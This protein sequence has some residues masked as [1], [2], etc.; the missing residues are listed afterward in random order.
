MEQKIEGG[1]LDRATK[2]QVQDKP[3]SAAQLMSLIVDAKATKDLLQG[4]LKDNAGAFAASVIDLYNSDTTLQQ[5]DPRQVFGECLKAASLKLPINKQLGFAWVIP[6]RDGKTGKQVPQFQI[7]YKGLVQLAMRSGVYRFI[8]AGAVLDGELKNEDKLRGLIDLSGEA[9]QGA[10]VIGYFA[11]IETLN[12]FSKALYW[13]KDKVNAH[14]RK[15]SKS[16]R[17]GSSIWRDNFDEMA[18]KTLLSNLLSH[19][20]L[21]SVE[22]QQAVS[23]DDVVLADNAL[24]QDAPVDVTPAPLGLDSGE[25]DSA[26]N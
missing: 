10:E 3:K 25:A 18:Q 2:T 14:A 1:M 6:Y 13:S 15:Y 23:N 11:Y 16:F 22:M 21:L 24:A 4:V 9:K 12:G 19:W 8:N 7:G 26:D 20:G 17:A 5:C